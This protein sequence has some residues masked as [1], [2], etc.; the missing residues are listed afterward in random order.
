MNSTG[1][2]IVCLL[3]SAS[4]TAFADWESVGTG[5]STNGGGQQIAAP[6]AP[7]APAPQ[8]DL[9]KPASSELLLPP[10]LYS[11]FLDA[12]KTTFDHVSFTYVSSSDAD[13]GEAFSEAIID[14]SCELGTVEDILSGD[15]YFTLKPAL[16]FFPNDAG[17]YSMPSML[18]RLPVDINWRWRYI[19]GWSFEAGAAPGIYADVDGL[20]AKMFGYPLRGI[21]YYAFD[22]EF[23]I[24]LG[25]E[26]RPGWDQLLMPHVGLAWEPNESFRL[27]FGLPK[28]LATFNL[29]QLD[30]FGLL[31]WQNATYAMSGDSPEPDDFTL[32]EW[33]LGL[34]ANLHFGDEWSLK[35][36]C[37][38][39][40]GRE[41]STEGTTDFS[42]DVD[43]AVYFGASVLWNLK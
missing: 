24:K 43:S 22:P 40:F 26:C 3:A 19:N 33:K 16:I 5:P 36:E 11:P 20:G 35:L 37:G 17:A 39:L 27:L 30:L 15:I 23:S 29:G 12:P 25:L 28:T 13:T 7:A 31:E 14:G 18:I 34:G 38:L 8:T 6:E 9:Y 10:D 1:K 21:F 42:T 4:L 32:N 41:I 2:L